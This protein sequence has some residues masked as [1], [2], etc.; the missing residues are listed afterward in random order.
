MSLRFLLVLLLAALA[1][2][3]S[4]PRWVKQDAS[5]EQAD[6]DDIDCQRQAAREA[7]LRAG[8]FYGP[9]YYGPYRLPYGRGAVSRRKLISRTTFQEVSHGGPGDFIG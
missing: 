8:G 4:T 2:A 9:A 5:A 3:C 6:R 1:G 7:S